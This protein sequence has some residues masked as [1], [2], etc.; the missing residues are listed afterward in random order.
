MKSK[1]IIISIFTAVIVVLICVIV[2]F[3]CNAEK[4]ST[5]KILPVSTYEYILNN[6]CNNSMSNNAYTNCV[7]D[8]LVKVKLEKVTQF[9]KISN[10]FK[11]DKKNVVLVND[12]NSNKDFM[13][14]YDASNKSNHTACLAEVYY[15]KAGSAY[16]RNLAECEIMKLI[17]D[18][19]IL[20]ETRSNFRGQDY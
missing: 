8:L 10:L 5:E 4:N 1:K 9:E 19:K 3:Y 18:I 12:N 20:D 16:E 13:D 11:T 15:T 2:Y 7:Q 17:D 14:W 6:G